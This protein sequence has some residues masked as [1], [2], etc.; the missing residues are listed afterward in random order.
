MGIYARYLGEWYRVDEGGSAGELPGLGGWAN[1]TDVSAPSGIKYTYTESETGTSWV[2]YEFRSDGTITIQEQGLMDAIVTGAGQNHATGNGGDVNQGTDLFEEGTHDVTVGITTS[3]FGGTSFITSQS[4][5]KNE[6]ISRGGGGAN[7]RGAGAMI[8][9][10]TST[11]QD[12]TPIY[13][14]ITGEEE[15]YGSGSA[16]SPVGKSYRGSGGDL[17]AH[18]TQ[19]ELD[20]CVILRVP[21]GNDLYN[22]VP[23]GWTEIPRGAVTKTKTTQK[24]TAIIDG[25]ETKIKRNRKR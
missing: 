7:S 18:Y 3:G 6:L 20:G 15:W 19:N 14:S 10:T 5:G 25:R 23:F 22:K 24:D 16:L 21:Q 17:A 1:I 9:G 4:T 11:N 8:G 13:S 12:S 2:A